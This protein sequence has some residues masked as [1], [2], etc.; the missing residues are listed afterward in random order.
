MCYKNKE[1]IDKE[2]TRMSLLE[3]YEKRIVM[4]NGKLKEYKEIMST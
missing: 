2:K 3:E 4:H 1:L